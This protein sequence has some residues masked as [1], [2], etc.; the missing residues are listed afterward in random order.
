MKTKIYPKLE[1]VP[2]DVILPGQ[3]HGDKVVEIISGNEDISNCDAFLTKNP[4]FSLGMRTAD[5]AAVC[6]SDGETIGIAHVGWRG[7]CLPL[8]ENM[9]KNF[10]SNKLTVF[11]GPFNHSFEIKRDFCFDEI[12]AKFGD[13]FFSQNGA[14]ITFLFKDAIMSMLPKNAELDIR[15]TFEDK[16]LP[17]FRRDSTKERLVTVVSF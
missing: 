4:N 7:L 17:S 2:R 6:F 3:V 10:D 9:L 11:V 14:K 13:K 16:N 12:Q 15:N 8:I 5:C 1:D